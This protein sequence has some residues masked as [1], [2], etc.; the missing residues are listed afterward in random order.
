MKKRKVADKDSYTIKYYGISL[1]VTGTKTDYEEETNSGGGFEVEEILLTDSEGN[2]AN[3][4]HWFGDI[5]IQ[6]ISRIVNEENY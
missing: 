4:M 5:Q 6:E 1:Y 3:I 2:E